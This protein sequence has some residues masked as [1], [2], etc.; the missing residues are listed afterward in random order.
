MVMA[1][2]TRMDYV[3]VVERVRHRVGLVK[4]KWV[5]GLRVN[6]NADNLKACQ[7]IPHRSSA[8]STE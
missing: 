8:R 6:V 5:V 4:V 7:V 1:W 3:E 2:W